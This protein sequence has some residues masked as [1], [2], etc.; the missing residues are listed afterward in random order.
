MRPWRYVQEKIMY[1]RK[2]ETITILNIHSKY[3]LSHSW[4][5]YQEKVLGRRIPKSISTI[6]NVKL[7]KF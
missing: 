6:P 7:Y 2:N 1:T 3:V 5:F 4:E